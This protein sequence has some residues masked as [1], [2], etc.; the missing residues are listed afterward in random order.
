MRANCDSR[1]MVAA[2]AVA[3][4]RPSVTARRLRTGS[5]PGNPRQ[6][7]QVAELGGAPTVTGQA[8]N[9]LERV[10]SWAWTSSPMTGKTLILLG[11][12]MADTDEY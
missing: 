6:T 2:A 8:Q 12:S 9:I 7:G 10:R 3:R 1:W 5:V 11:V 4:R